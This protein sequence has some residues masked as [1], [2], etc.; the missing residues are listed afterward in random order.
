VVTGLV[1]VKQKPPS[2]AASVPPLEVPPSEPL[3]VPPSEPLLDPDPEPPPEPDPD[4][5]PDDDPDDEPE[6][7]PDELDVVPPSLALF[8]ALTVQPATAS[9]A[10]VPETTTEPDSTQILFVEII[11]ATS[12]RT[13]GNRRVLSLMRVPLSLAGRRGSWR[14]ANARRSLG[15][16]AACLRLADG[17]VRSLE[18]GL[19][20]AALVVLGLSESALGRLEAAE[21]RRHV[22]LI[23]AGAREA[24]L[25]IGVLVR[26]RGLDADRGDESGG[27]AE[28]EGLP[29]VHVFLLNGERVIGCAGHRALLR[30]DSD[31]QALVHRAGHLVRAVFTRLSA[32]TL[33]IAE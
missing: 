1:P 19:A 2:L 25:G 28:G 14:C 15:E 33:P 29:G 10:A 9:S 22:G 23:V 8:V 21:R 32:R 30:D 6:D 16:V 12:L 20:P 13:F 27:E 24:R 11:E 18:G 5:P 4:D 31:G 3:E 7:D 26:G 17:R